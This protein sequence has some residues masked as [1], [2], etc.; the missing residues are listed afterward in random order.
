MRKIVLLATCAGLAAVAPASAGDLVE[1]GKA[2]VTLGW[3]SLDESNDEG[4]NE[5]DDQSYGLFGLDASYSIPLAPDWS[6]QADVLAEKFMVSGSAVNNVSNLMAGGLHVTYR[7]PEQYAVGA[8]AGAGF[9]DTRREDRMTTTP[10]GSAPKGSTTFRTPPSMAS[11]RIRPATL[12]IPRK[13]S[14]VRGWCAVS[15][16]IS[17][18]TTRKSKVNFPTQA[19]MMPLMVMMKSAISHGD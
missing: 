8:F 14:R 7:K 5:T 15:S 3:T 19:Q 6:V 1:T 12:R 13:S 10:G 9:G 2:S 4:S 16:A 11:W 17:S 18:M